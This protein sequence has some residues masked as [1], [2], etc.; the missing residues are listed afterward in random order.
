MCD[1]LSTTHL[2]L[3]HDNSSEA[4]QVFI[5][6]DLPSRL[7]QALPLAYA[8]H[9]QGDAAGGFGDEQGVGFY[10]DKWTFI[11]TSTGLRS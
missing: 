2:D 9:R 11:K 1:D 4:W 7:Q 3:I 10:G 5:P 6:H 8:S